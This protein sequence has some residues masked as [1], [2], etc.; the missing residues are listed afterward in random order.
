MRL[1][2]PWL[3]ARKGGGRANG[4]R[5]DDLAREVQP[6]FGRGSQDDAGLGVTESIAS[7]GPRRAEQG[8]WRTQYGWLQ[9]N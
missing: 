4:S 7:Q 1:G 9:G 6:K 2:A 3:K 5:R 8:L